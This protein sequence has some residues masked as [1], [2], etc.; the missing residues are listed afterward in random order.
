MCEEVSWHIRLTN[1]E[2]WDE[3]YLMDNKFTSTY[4]AE[5]SET[6][7]MSLIAQMG[8]AV[9]VGDLEMVGKLISENAD[10]SGTIT[11]NGVKKTFRLN[12]A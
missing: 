9:S 4:A 1:P 2:T 12:K 6:S 8:R 3:K 5:V 10:I 11:W 7:V